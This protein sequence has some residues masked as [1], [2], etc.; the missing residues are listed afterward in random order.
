MAIA[1]AT[2]MSAPNKGAD[3]V[4]TSTPRCVPSSPLTRCHGKGIII[5]D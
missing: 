4:E 1:G 5:F 2:E 3:G